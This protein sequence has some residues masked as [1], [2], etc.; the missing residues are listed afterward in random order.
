M[1]VTLFVSLQY[2][3]YSTILSSLGSSKNSPISDNAKPA[4]LITSSTS[5][6]TEITASPEPIAP[7]NALIKMP[8]APW[9]KGSLL[10]RTDQV[11]DFSKPKT[12]KRSDT[13]KSDRTLNA[14]EVGGKK[15]VKKIVG[16]I[17]NLHQNQSSE[18]TQMGFNG[19][20]IGDCFGKLE[21]G[22][23]DS[24]LDKRLPWVRDGRL[25]IRRMK[26]DKV[27]TAAELCLDEEL[28]QRLREEATR[29]T[30][31]VKVNKA[32]VTQDVVDEIRLIWRRDELAMLKFNLPLCRSMDRARE[33][34]ELK[35][36]GL[37]VWKRKE[38]L[39]VYRGC[40]R[41]ITSKSFS[42]M[43][44]CPSNFSQQKCNGSTMDGGIYRGGGEGNPSPSGLF[45]EGCL[46]SQPLNGSLF[47][48]ETD[49]LLDGLGPRFIDW[50]MQKPLPVD[51]DLLT[52]FVPGF[53][54][55]R[56]LCPSLV[57]SK[58][59][60]AELTYLRHHAQA[61]PIHFALGRNRRLQ[62]LAAAILKLWEKSH[63]AKIAVKWGIPNTDNE[64]MADELKNLTGGVLL[65]RNRFFIILY[66][67]KDF[68]PCQVADLVVEREMELRKCQTIEEGARQFAVEDL[69]M[70][71]Q[72]VANSSSIGTLS[73]FQDIQ[74]KY[75]NMGKGNKEVELQL[76]AEKE[77]LK[78]ELKKQER[79]L[80]ILNCNIEKSTKELLKLNSRWEPAGLE[81]DQE[82][83]T[84][85]ERSC[86]RKIG[87]KMDGS[88]VLGR[89]GVFDGV[90]EGIHQHWK[91]KEVV[92]VITMQR[93]FAD[94]I[95]SAKLL[96]VESGGI[97]VSVEKLKEGHAI[98]IYRGKNYRRPPKLPTQ[99]LLSRRQA[100]FRSL[101]MQRLGSLKFFAHQRRRT[102]SDLKLKL[103]ELHEAGQ[104]KFLEL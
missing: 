51:A 63:I 55:P 14:K 21:E 91:H 7:S 69:S 26:K 59:T 101:E 89:R 58:L 44:S 37:V 103:A 8:T 104:E 71:D 41:K 25:V 36:G 13:E 53:K 84:E 28:L 30:K 87:K 77:N 90:I 32:G 99:N 78:R 56:R 79:K 40:N 43:K 88:L 57:R 2:R 10:L 80:F 20:K 3:S 62:G 76:Q 75:E 16:S 42:N 6:G 29:M 49:R 73:E 31:W 39:V 4:T 9:M 61:L 27:V 65:L 45:M 47:E 102:I 12:K 94:I 18:D 19:L 64:Q 34:V 15:A 68:L 85:E 23:G 74:A 33:I 38:F 35:T 48:R 100:L 11:L 92:K 97:F 93:L 66:R 1:T 98:I 17:E 54:T 70:S 24:R 82:T 46:D 52:Q 22:Y 60:D 83:I 95:Y 5:N 81:A 67:G 86:L 50:W 72:P 96:E